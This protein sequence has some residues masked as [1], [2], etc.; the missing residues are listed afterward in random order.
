MRNKEV[1][2]KRNVFNSIKEINRIR[3]EILL[4]Y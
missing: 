3:K 4:C 1:I 2:E